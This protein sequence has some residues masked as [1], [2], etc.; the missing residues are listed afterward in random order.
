MRLLAAFLCLVALVV[1]PARGQTPLGVGYQPTIDTAPLFVAKEQGIFARHGL[2]VPLTSGVGQMQIA[3]VTAGSLQIGQ[4]TI[5][6]VMQAIESG[7]D[8]VII[9]GDNF[10][11][12]GAD[13]FGLVERKGLDLRKPQAFPGKRVGV[14]TVGA[15]LQ[16]LFADWLRRGG[17]DPH[18]VTFVEVPFPSMAD[19]LRQGTVDAVLP[20]E[21][22]IT[23]MVQAGV[24]DLVTDYIRDV[25]PGLP[26]AVYV[27]QR[28]WAN[29][30]R[31]QVEAFRASLEEGH[32]FLL[33]DS[34][35]GMADVG[36]W[37]K[38]PSTVLAAQKLPV[39]HVDVP[40]AGLTE[41]GQ[42][43]LGQ[44]LIH[45]KPDVSRMVWK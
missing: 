6:Q 44:Q 41:W 1:A 27:A 11:A 23:R 39:I 20:V 9:A 37:L 43:L 22:F 42:I 12:P 38:L 4:P 5:P 16:V 8:L 3:G 26:V 32:K 17:V 33:A 35:Q 2:G 28:D 40:E 29:G 24:G 15:F 14:N 36:K 10:T 21:P 31:T 45:S 34:E 18:S 13:E 7:L 19:V 25:P 30:H